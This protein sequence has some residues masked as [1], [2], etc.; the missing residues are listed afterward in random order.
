[1]VGNISFYDVTGKRQHTVYI[2]EAAEYGKGTFFSAWK[3]EIAIVK[4]TLS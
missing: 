4:K 2:G 3:N 1:M